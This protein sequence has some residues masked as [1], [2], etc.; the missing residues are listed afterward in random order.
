MATLSRRFSQMGNR[1]FS[2]KTELIK[3]YLRKFAS[4]FSVNLRDPFY[5]VYI[6][7]KIE[8]LTL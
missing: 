1:K 2:Q 6:D 5:V 4:I 7:L 8:I 3:S